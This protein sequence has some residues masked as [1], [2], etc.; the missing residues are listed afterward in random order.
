MLVR[1]V[2]SVATSMATP[3]MTSQHPLAPRLM[4]QWPLGVAGKFKGWVKRLG[5]ETTV[6]V[7]VA[8]VKT[9]T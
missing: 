9:K 7:G 5:A 3:R 8:S 1:L 6:W 4:G 2:G